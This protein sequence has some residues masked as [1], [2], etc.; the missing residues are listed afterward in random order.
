MFYRAFFDAVTFLNRTGIETDNI[1]LAGDF[2]SYDMEDPIMTIIQGGYISVA[3]LFESK[4][5]SYLFDGQFGDLDYVFIKNTSSHRVVGAR[6]WHVNSDEVDALD[7]NTDYGRDKSLFNGTVP[8]RYSDH[9]PI[10]VKVILSESRPTS[11]PSA[12]TT[13]K[14]TSKP[15]VR[16]SSKPTSKPLVI[17]SPILQPSRKPSSTPVSVSPECHDNP[18]AMFTLRNGATRTCVQLA[19][20]SSKRRTRICNSVVTNAGKVCPVRVSAT[21]FLKS[22]Q[23][24]SILMPST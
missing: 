13:K 18:L 5:Y 24:Q 8:Y 11:S 19:S 2:N 16:P 3:S 14:P 6:T 17:P 12:Q 1:V 9:D 20:R 10:V 23:H 21:L 22:W 7:Y 4:P 15:F